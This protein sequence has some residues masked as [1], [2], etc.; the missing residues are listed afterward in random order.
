[1][2]GEVIS[3]AAIPEVCTDAQS[4]MMI[5]MNSLSEKLWYTEEYSINL[6]GRAVKHPAVPDIT[7]QR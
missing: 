1:M 2:T 7:W 5:H 4:Q 3:I 6:T